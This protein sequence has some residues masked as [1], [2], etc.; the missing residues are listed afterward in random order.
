VLCFVVLIRPPFAPSALPDF[1]ATMG[2]SDFHPPM[3]IGS[4]VKLAAGCSP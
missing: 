4:L 2:A 1:D 3:A